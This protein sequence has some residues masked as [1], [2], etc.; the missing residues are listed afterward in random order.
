MR[1]L[2]PSC[3]NAFITGVQE[4]RGGWKGYVTKALGFSNEGL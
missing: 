3:W 1:S 2:R 4:D